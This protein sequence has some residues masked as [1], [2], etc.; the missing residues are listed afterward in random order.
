M[1][2]LQQQLRT[3]IRRHPDGTRAF[4]SLMSDAHEAMFGAGLNEGKAKAYCAKIT[5]LKNANT[6]SALS[7]DTTAQRDAALHALSEICN[8]TDDYIYDDCYLDFFIPV[9]TDNGTPPL[10]EVPANVS[11]QEDGWACTS[12]HQTWEAETPESDIPKH[13]TNCLFTLPGYTPLRHLGIWTT[14]EFD[15]ECESVRVTQT[16][17]SYNAAIGEYNECV[18]TPTDGAYANIL[19]VTG[20]VYDVRDLLTPD[21]L[22]EEALTSLK[23][24]G[25]P[26]LNKI[27]ELWARMTASPVRCNLNHGL[28]SIL[29][30]VQTLELQRIIDTAGAIPMPDFTRLASQMSLFDGYIPYEQL[31][32]K[33]EA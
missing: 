8:R 20:V 4:S 16:L 13:C 2:D 31:A 24:A 21:R 32:A 30:G 1:Q 18:L 15:D 9:F 26:N 5:G 3:L 10:P 29:R 27:A 11:K 6:F 23:D 25:D 33:P 14:L 12:C 28:V 7:G 17:R 19:E 22:R